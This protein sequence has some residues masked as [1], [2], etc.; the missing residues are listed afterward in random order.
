MPPTKASS[1]S[2]GP[3]CTFYRSTHD[4]SSPNPP[5]A[6]AQFFYTSLLP[7]DDPISPVPP[8]VSGSTK[9]S[10]HP[11]RPF[12]AYDNAA[13]EEA[14]LELTKDEPK[15]EHSSRND[16]RDKVVRISEPN[17]TIPDTAHHDKHVRRH[18]SKDMSSDVPA[19]E[20]VKEVAHGKRSKP[21]KRTSSKLAKG[22]VSGE[23]ELNVLSTRE[24]E[25]SDPAGGSLRRRF[26][27]HFRA[28]EG[29]KTSELQIK[30]YESGS[31]ALKAQLSEP[32]AYGTSPS[33]TDTTGTP[34]IRAP[35]RLDRSRPTTGT[36]SANENEARQ[37]GGDEL[38]EQT[39]SEQ[40]SLSRPSSRS[41]SRP[42]IHKSKSKSRSRSRS[43][44][45]HPP[46][47]WKHHNREA[48]V[49]V[50]VS[51]LHL[52][53]LPA[54]Q[55]EPIYWSPV[56]DIAP[57]VRGTWFYKVSWFPVEL[58]VANRLEEGYLELKPWTETWND[59][60]NCAVEVGAEG[61]VKITHRLY[62]EG[63]LKSAGAGG[64]SSLSG[65][66][67]AETNEV[68]SDERC[69]ERLHSNQPASHDK[70]I[71]TAQPRV[72]YSNASVIYSDFE[73]AFILRPNQVPSS[74]YSRR[75]LASI[76]KG[77]AVGIPVVR[78]FDCQAW[79]RLHPPKRSATNARA[80]EGSKASRSGTADVDNS[81]KCEECSKREEKPK[82]T[83]LVLVIHG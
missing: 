32:N 1:H 63:V 10:K 47:S 26:T 70:H 53:R 45:C 5:A 80:Q 29:S 18:Q 37:T 79:E 43:R 61:E 81:A 20:G 44:S 78:G 50:G 83:D 3:T 13:L 76:L 59:E 36:D 48:T 60:L 11:T 21:K 7:I 65:E 15:K 55:M 24:Q 6:K 2:F 46:H 23:G 64:P 28:K 34:F 73:N 75:P 52:V 16:G 14:W 74:Y 41:S 82:V 17:D 49:P 9:V 71:K 38:S 39:S 66:Q 72:N 56:H 57:V 33:E 68:C 30:Y 4:A 25:H 77:K 31:L 27:S 35:S 19:A 22:H 42:S 58:E 54:M 62:P 51:R 40:T 69:A 67:T 12:S 8:P